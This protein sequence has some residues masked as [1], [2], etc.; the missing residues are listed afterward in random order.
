MHN[1]RFLS[2]AD[3]KVACALM[4]IVCIDL[5]VRDT[6]G[7]V[8][9][10]LRTNQPAAGSWFLPGGRIRKGERLADA[11]SRL[12]RQELGVR[13]IEMSDARL[14]GVYEHFYETDFT[15]D[16][17]AP[18]HYVTLAYEPAMGLELALPEG[19]QHQHWAWMTVDALLN[20]PSVHPWTK[21]CFEP[22]PR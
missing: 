3:Y 2:D 4:P 20:H 10:G 9:L 1:P 7:R 21:A 22:D 5:L 6:E 12:A 11:F 15:G 18:T 16:P 8:L 19:E 13:T 17:S 14:H